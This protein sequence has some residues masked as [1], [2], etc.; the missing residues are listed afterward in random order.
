MELQSQMAMQQHMNR[1]ASNSSMVLSFRGSGNAPAA[2]GSINTRRRESSATTAHMDIELPAAVISGSGGIV[3]RTFRV[4]SPPSSGGNSMGSDQSEIIRRA[5]EAGAM[6]QDG[7]VMPMSDNEN[8]SP[9]VG[10]AVSALGA[11]SGNSSI[12]GSKY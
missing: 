6:I 10:S 7:L 2:A 9:E 3:D 12:N 5:L 8:R 11:S 1:S 4:G